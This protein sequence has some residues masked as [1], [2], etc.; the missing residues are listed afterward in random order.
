M[1]TIFCH[2]SQIVQADA[3]ESQSNEEDCSVRR[4]RKVHVH[5]LSLISEGNVRDLVS[6]FAT[7]ASANDSFKLFVSDVRLRKIFSISGVVGEEETNHVGQLMNCFVLID[8]V[9]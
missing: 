8:L 9:Y 6:P 2:A 7:F 4:I 3:E 1:R 5:D